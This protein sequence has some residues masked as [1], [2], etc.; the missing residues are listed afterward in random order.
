MAE[1]RS[2]RYQPDV[3][4]TLD[5]WREELGRDFEQVVALLTDR[6]RDLEDY[7]SSIQTRLDLLTSSPY[8][9][10][11][12][13]AYAAA[14]STASAS[15]VDYPGPINA[16]FTKLYDAATSDLIVTGWIGAYKTTNTG[17]VDVGLARDG[18][19]QMI[20]DFFYNDLSSHRNIS[21]TER[22]TGMSAGAKSWRV[23]WRTSNNGVSADSNDAVR[24]TIFEVPV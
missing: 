24:L 16:N 15:F 1:P 6:D 19:D 14:G 9:V 8:Q 17:K 10:W 23:R 4:S 12:G 18:G 7:L 2:F 13:A 11:V 21:C 3:R 22:I 20:G 5:P